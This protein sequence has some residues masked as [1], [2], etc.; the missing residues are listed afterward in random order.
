MT[1]DG[2]IPASTGKA[3]TLADGTLRIVFEFEPRHAQAAFALFGVSGS[4]C[5]IARLTQEASIA[6]QQAETVA[7]DDI[8]T[9]YEKPKGGLLARLAGQ[10]CAEEKFQSWMCVETEAGAAKLVR[11]ICVVDSRAELDH[12]E[13]AAERFHTQI[14]K[15]YVEWLRQE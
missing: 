5:V 4:P 11:E 8:P 1:R 15:P 10:L 3:S 2:L 9:A 14:R 7:G 13:M 6:A 12:N